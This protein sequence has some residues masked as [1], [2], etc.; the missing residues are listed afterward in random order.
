MCLNI[1]FPLMAAYYNLEALNFIPFPFELGT[2]FG[3]AIKHF[4]HQKE[5]QLPLIKL[6][7]S[8]GNMHGLVKIIYYQLNKMEHFF[9]LLLSNCGAPVLFLCY[10]GNSRICHVLCINMFL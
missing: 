3:A 8:T 7:K 5:V 10:Y 1:F 2:L 9:L 4:K 6:N